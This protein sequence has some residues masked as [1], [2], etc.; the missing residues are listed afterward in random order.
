MAIDTYAPCPGGT[1]KK[2]K[3]CCA[4]LVGDLEQ[5]DRL[6][7]GDQ[8]SAAL[9]QVRRLS[10]KHPDRPCL[11]ATRTK[12]E[13]G[14]KQFAEAAVSS[15]AFLT[16]HPEN[17]L[18][19]GQAAV[20]DAVAGRVQEAAAL[21]DKARITA[22]A[23]GR[24]EGGHD[25]SPE[26]VRI[27][28]T[29]VQAGAQLGHVGFAQGIVE[30]LFDRGLGS[31]EERRLLAAIVGS[32]GVPPALRT[33]VRLA[34]TA[35][36]AAWRPEF[37]AALEHARQWRLSKALTAFRSLKS[38]AG[39][40]R[41][42]F[43]NIAL[44]CEML[45]RPFEAAEAWLAVAK[46]RDVSHDDAVEATGR[47]IALET[48]ADPDRSPLVSFATAI[49]ALAVGT[50]EEGT[51]ALELLEDKLRHD[52]RCETAP[53]DRSSWVSRGA[54]PPR[55]V[56]RIYEPAAGGDRPARMLASLLVFGR[57]TDREPEAVL[58]G[59]APD[60]A[61]ARPI[62]EELL[63]CT[64]TGAETAT[65]MPATP[66]TSWLMGGQFRMPAAEP[67]TAPPAAGSPCLFDTL[68]ARQQAALW[69]RFVDRWPETPL[70][71]LLGKTPR[72]ALA[73]AEGTRRVEALVAE[74]EAT[75]RR[76]DAADAWTAVRQQLGMP[77][78]APIVEEKPLESVPPLRWH[79]LDMAKVDLD[80]LRGVLV[81]SVDAGFDRAAERAA[82]AVVARGDTTPE[83]RWEAYGVLEERADSTVRKLELLGE[84]RS[85]AKALK[86]N[87]GML[88]VAELRV[89]LQRGDQA[90]IM[91]LLDHL[92]REHTRD[93]QVL[94]AVAEV[95][96]EAGVDLNALAGRA[97]GG[98]PGA[99][100]P[101]MSAAAPAA[102]PG[103]LWTPGG[104]TAGGGEKK[105]IWTPG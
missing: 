8:I 9:D 84:L 25:V 65:G 67:P 49:A 27:A 93:Q 42:L 21:F 83:D 100:V 80:Q 22:L 82:E 40:S 91:R 39:E 60:V 45:A 61:E 6:I 48:E 81:T 78:A 13:L 85:I 55:S 72:Q 90:D 38:V 87:D 43:T 16:A 58:Q 28:A 41:E 47:A 88:D 62:A 57:Q 73:D 86:A 79:R 30:W 63:G 75:S 56:W 18:A 10:D 23:A 89:R 15:Q 95:L 26:L 14:T 103:K 33:K 44:I 20:T 46:L 71:E 74:G 101:G 66:P 34:P 54:V 92:R 105:T 64:F 99:T 12:L 51:T 31:D 11:M 19:L 53:F 35:A 97:A 4:D 17:P 1:G 37:D 36:D 77:A 29:L 104:E 2:I 59:F 76:R 96:M 3:F 70:P 24:T 68:M 7:E 102:E 94:Q 69:S 50:G 32:A 52:S 5:L 98:M